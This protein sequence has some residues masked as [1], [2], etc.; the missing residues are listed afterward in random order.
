MS[1]KVMTS[2]SAFGDD[3]P[4]RC[5]P[6]K[7]GTFYTILVQSVAIA[8]SLEFDSLVLILVQAI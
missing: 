6:K 1:S 4:Y 3:L 7:N 2:L 5:Q 8:D